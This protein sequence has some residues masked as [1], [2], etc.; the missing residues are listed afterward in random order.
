MAQL[1]GAS[2]QT[3]KG[4]GFD[5]Q[6]GHTPILQVPSP[7]RTHTK[8]AVLSLAQS[9]GRRQPTDQCFSL[10]VSVSFSLPLPLSLKSIN[11]SLGED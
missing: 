4:C 9:T 3:P 1:A 8:V 7:V 11:I 6:S 2:P 10:N 5:S